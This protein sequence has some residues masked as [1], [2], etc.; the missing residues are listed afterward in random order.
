MLTSVA[1]ATL[2]VNV[3]PVHVGLYA[4]FV[5][6]ERLR[7][8]FVA[9]AALSLLGT[10]VLLGE[11]GGGPED[12]RGMLLALVASLFY[13]A[14]ILVMG[15]ARREI[16]VFSG[17]YLMTLGAA[18]V[19]GLAA[20]AIG[21]PLRGF[22]ASSWGV[23]LAAAVVSQLV[24]VFGIVWALRYVPATLTSVGLLGQP[25]GAALRGLGPL[26][27]VTPVPRGVPLP[28][29]GPASREGAVGVAA[30]GGL[31]A[32]AVAV[33]GGP[34]PAAAAPGRGGA[35]AGSSTSPGGRSR[36]LSRPRRQG[37][38][39]GQRW[40]HTI[41]LGRGRRQR[42]YTA[43]G[44][45]PNLLEV[46]ALRPRVPEQNRRASGRAEEEAGRVGK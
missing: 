18:T 39:Q 30:G 5:R 10:V 45:I 24:G 2:L 8:G 38:R 21:D 14:Y 41:D 9:G 7:T 29:G 40:W 25:V 17:L 22:P 6:G 4:R 20:L 33:G 28:P 3:T 32:A 31:V 44:F 11:P 34:P 27:Q 16:D 46:W 19:L 36:L 23:M 1:T 42:G 37:R 15:Q 13:A 12:L 35:A 43:R 26:V